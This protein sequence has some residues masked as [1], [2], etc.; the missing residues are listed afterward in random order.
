MSGLDTQIGSILA[1]DSDGNLYL[2]T[3]QGSP[4]H[5]V[6]RKSTDHGDT[7]SIVFD[8]TECQH[9]HNAQ[10]PEPGLLS[11]PEQGDGKEHNTFYDCGR[12][13]L[14]Q[15]PKLMDRG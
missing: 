14:A 5:C 12:T 15:L 9:V 1:E 3:Y 6:I 8:T 13:P 4:W 10:L 11:L 2:G 7:W